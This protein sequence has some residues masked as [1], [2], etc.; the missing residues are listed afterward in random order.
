M[1]KPQKNSNNKPFHIP[2]LEINIYI[3]INKLFTIMLCSNNYLPSDEAV[4]LKNRS[5]E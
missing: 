5:V 3:L 1:Y 2:V 4:I